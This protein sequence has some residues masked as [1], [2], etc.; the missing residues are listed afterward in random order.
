L[1][2]IA[3]WVERFPLGLPRLLATALVSFGEL[4]AT[5]GFEEKKKD[6]ISQHLKLLAIDILLSLTAKN[7]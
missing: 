4:P 5:V 3:E 7:L 6:H 1:K 2:L